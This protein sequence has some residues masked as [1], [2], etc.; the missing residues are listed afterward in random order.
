MKKIDNS[1]LFYLKEKAFLYRFFAFTLRTS[2]ST[3]MVNRM[4]LSLLRTSHQEQDE[5][6][7]IAVALAVTSRSHLELILNQLQAYGAVFTNKD[8]SHFLTLTK[9]VSMKL[10]FLNALTKM[11][12]IICAHQLVPP[13]TNFPCAEELEQLLMDILKEEPLDTLCSSIQL[14]AI[15]LIADLRAH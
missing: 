4:V 14:N 10:V 6:E 3:E 7:G 5:R 15:S 11:I 9:D 1:D 2:R 13:T 12:N 8:S